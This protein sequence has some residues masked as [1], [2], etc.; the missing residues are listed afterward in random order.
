M[1]GFS[2]KIDA[3]FDEA[4]SRVR[5]ALQKEGFGVLT[6]IDVKQTLKKKLDVDFRRYVILGAC[7]PPFAYKALTAEL[8]IGLLLPCNVIVYENDEGG[9]TVAAMDASLMATVTGND[10]LSEVA[11]TVNEKL[12]RVIETF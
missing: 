8:E 10:Q 7:N 2:R 5:G 12:K 9:T 11:A 3:G 4:V 1:Y 6:E